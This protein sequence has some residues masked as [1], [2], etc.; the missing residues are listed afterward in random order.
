[1]GKID[2]LFYIDKRINFVIELTFLVF[3]SDFGGGNKFNR[4]GIKT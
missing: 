2:R 3:C 1:M 4:I